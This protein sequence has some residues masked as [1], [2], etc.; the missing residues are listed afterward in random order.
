MKQNYT[1]AEV[2]NIFAR[3]GY[4]FYGWKGSHYRVKRG[5]KKIHICRHSIEGK[6]YLKKLFKKAGIPLEELK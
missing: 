1:F 5:Q 3:Y 2:I 6:E 4:T